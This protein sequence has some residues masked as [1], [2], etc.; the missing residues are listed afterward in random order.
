MI[1]VLTKR[2]D[3]SFTFAIILHYTAP[4]CNTLQHTAPHCTTLHHT[5]THN[6]LFNIHYS[7]LILHFDYYP[8]TGFT[9]A[10]WAPIFL[11]E[12]LMAFS[13]LA[14]ASL[15]T[16]GSVWLQVCL[17]QMNIKE[18]NPH[19][20]WQALYVC[21]DSTYEFIQTVLAMKYVY[22]INGCMHTYSA[23]HEM[24]CW[25]SVMLCIC[26]NRGVVFVCVCVCVL[27]VR[28]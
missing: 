28:L 13:V 23:C 26:L 17:W 24:Q 21:I 12:M 19:I 10:I 15:A 20:S 2:H 9:F 27:C 22:F 8:R 25:E 4:H 7:L 14:P 11:G 6:L 3:S 1:I 16:P 18:A 5:A